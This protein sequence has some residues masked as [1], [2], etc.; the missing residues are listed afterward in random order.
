MKNILLATILRILSFFLR[1]ANLGNGTTWPGHLALKVNPHFIEEIIKEKHI[2]PIVVAGTNGKTT[3]ARILQTI[4]EASGKRVFQ[5]DSGANLLNGIASTLILNSET[6]TE[7]SPLYAIFEVDENALPKLLKKISPK[8][9]LLLNLFRDQLDRYGEVRTIAKH[10][11]DSL[12][13]SDTSIEILGNGDDPQIVGICTT[14]QQKI[15]YFGLTAGEKQTAE[16]TADSSYCPHCGAKLTYSSVQFSHLGDWKCPSCGLKRP[17]VFSEKISLPLFG[18]Y[19]AYNGA[20]ACLTALKLGL[21]RKTITTGLSRVTP[22]FGRQETFVRDGK[23]IQIFLSKNP[24]GMNESLRT[25]KELGGTYLLFI[26]ND[27]IP[28]GKDVSWIWDVDIET[29]VRKD[30]RIFTSGDRAF[31]MGLRIKYAH[32]VIDH[33][34]THEI[35]ETAFNDILKSVPKEETLFILP[36]YSAM[37]DV[38]KLLTGRKIL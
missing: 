11:Q 2:I 19:N 5:N 3:T 15:E 38:R 14:L 22:A 7:K 31:D 29:L 36:T 26:L 10:W 25:I 23:N 9:L 34:D 28:D 8:Y 32:P 24:T 35:L 13:D 16:H 33:V 27:R 17:K 1:V 20:A 30:S 4:L 6:G 18:S 37:L 12:L 21:Q